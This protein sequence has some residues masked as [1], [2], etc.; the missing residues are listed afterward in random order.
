MSGAYGRIE[1]PDAIQKT[2]HPKGAAEYDIFKL[3]TQENEW[4]IRAIKK[5]VTLKRGDLVLDVGGR[6]GNVAFALQKA[7]Q[8]HIIDPDPRIRPLKRPGRFWRM[9][10]QDVEFDPVVK[11]K[12]IIC[13]HV[14]GYLSLQGADKQV[15]KK[16][17]DQLEIGGTLVLF[18][19]TNDGYMS[20]LLEY[21]RHILP[22]RHFD[23]FDELLLRP[24]EINHDIKQLDTS[25]DLAYRDFPALARCCWFLFGAV[26]RNIDE[27]ARRFL[28]KLRDDLAQP[29]FPIGERCKLIR[30]LF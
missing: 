11:Y 17:T 1:G 2:W 13:C 25:F 27:C 22:R 14:L 3:R 29:L 5:H 10:I 24:Y 7:P 16:L 19:N 6:D 23:E 28:P 12:L 15:L 30:K 4:L 8:V 21:S 26:D 9:K 18:Y 20:S